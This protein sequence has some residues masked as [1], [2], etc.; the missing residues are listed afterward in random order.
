[1]KR[2]P[3]RS[4][5]TDTL[6]PYTTLFRSGAGQWFRR[7]HA[8][9]P[10]VRRHEAERLWP[11]RRRAGPARIPA[12]QEC[13]DERRPAAARAGR[14]MTGALLDP[15]QRPQRGFDNQSEL[16]GPPAPEPRTLLAEASLHSAYA[17]RC[18]RQTAGGGTRGSVQ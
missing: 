5:R 8:A 2:R 3:P 14:D 11:P 15:A 1:M 17:H 16:L 4:T 12:G 13:L 18:A 7:R 6:F 10:A 9:E